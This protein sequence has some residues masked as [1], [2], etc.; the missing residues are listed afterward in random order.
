MRR[1]H[2]DLRVWVEAITL[3]EEIYALSAKFP[4][5]EQFGLTGQMRRAAISIPSNIAEGAARKGRKEL[6]NFLS[7]ANGSLSELDTQL[8][9]A[10][11]LHYIDPTIPSATAWTAC[12]H[13]WPP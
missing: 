10:V 7:I 9:I 8:E 6:L 12:S 1:A 3:V 5:Q 4:R 13:C 11:R 2:R